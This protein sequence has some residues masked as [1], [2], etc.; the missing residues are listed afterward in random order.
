MKTVILA[1]KKEF[2]ED[3]QQRLRSFGTVVYSKN[4]KEYSHEELVGLCNNAQILAPDPDNLG[5]FEKAKGNLNLLIGRLPSL[6]GIALSTTSYGWVDLEFCK[7]RRLPV[8][9]IPHYSRESVAE[10]SFAL[11]LCLAKRIIETDRLTRKGQYQLQMGF[12][13]KGKTLGIIGL[14]SIGSRVAEL[15]LAI[16]MKVIAYN[17]TPIIQKS[18]E[19]KSLQEV[20]KQSDALSIHL[21][22]CEETRGIIGKKEI[23]LMKNGA[24]LVNTADRRMVDEKEMAKA[25]KTRKIFGYAAEVEDLE[26]TPLAKIDNAILI[27]GFG[28]YTKEALNNLVE[29]WIEN[30][31]S[32]VKG[33]PQNVVSW[34]S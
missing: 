28:W 12:E 2:S 23:S 5:G 27:R 9:N 17:R 33:K 16:G 11:L 4:R 30:I 3:Q 24:I 1:P 21:T 10:H 22:D 13:L 18:V 26:N 14:G 32:M 7:K 34:S 15:G 6:K 20:L 8:V 31:E 25:L 19:M 29:I